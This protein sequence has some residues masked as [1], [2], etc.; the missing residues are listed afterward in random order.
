[1]HTVCVINMKFIE[2]KSVTDKSLDNRDVCMHTFLLTDVLSQNPIY[3]AAV[4]YGC[5]LQENENRVC[6]LNEFAKEL[7][8]FCINS[9]FWWL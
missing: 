4:A 5:Q 7:M 1:M 8:L 2:K 6:D 9:R 3:S